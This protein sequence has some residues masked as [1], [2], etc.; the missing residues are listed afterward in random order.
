M[1]VPTT[2]KTKS[3]DRLVVGYSKQKGNGVRSEITFGKGIVEKV[4]KKHQGN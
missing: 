4:L 1:D 3:E 2:V